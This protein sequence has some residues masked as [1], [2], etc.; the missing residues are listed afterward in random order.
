MKFLGPMQPLDPYRWVKCNPQPSCIAK[1]YGGCL[2]ITIV[3]ALSVV[4][5][6][7]FSLV[8]LVN[9]HREKTS[10]KVKHIL[11]RFL[12]GSRDSSYVVNII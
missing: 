12:V 2:I 4:L 9:T 6:S 1:V 7:T 10:V 11:P 3:C 5:E 8:P